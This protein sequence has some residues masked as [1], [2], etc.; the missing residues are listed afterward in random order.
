MDSWTA[1]TR[2]VCTN[3]HEGI[4]LR[5][6]CLYARML[7]PHVPWTHVPWT[8]D[9]RGINLDYAPGPA[10]SDNPVDK[11][12]RERDK[13]SVDISARL[14]LLC[15][16]GAE[17]GSCQRARPQPH[18]AGNLPRKAGRN[19]TEA[20][21]KFSRRRGHEAINYTRQARRGEAR[22]ITKRASARRHRT[23]SAQDARNLLGP[24]GRRARCGSYFGG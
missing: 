12:P 19:G 23:G 10:K 18:M 2:A 3:K 8:R 14:G 16:A 5:P 17:R 1:S 6:A 4:P 9:L 21:A 15:S 13:P 11:L 22:L 20:P 24:H 7:R